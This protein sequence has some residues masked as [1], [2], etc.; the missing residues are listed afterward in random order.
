M[1]PLPGGAI[2]IKAAAKHVS[3]GSQGHTSLQFKDKR[4]PG[5]RHAICFSD[6]GDFVL[7]SGGMSSAAAQTAAHFICAVWHVRPK[8]CCCCIH[9]SQVLCSNIVLLLCV[10]VGGMLHAV[11]NLARTYVGPTLVCPQIVLQVVFSSKQ[12]KQQDI[13]NLMIARLVA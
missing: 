10:R 13:E 8:V 6:S 12:N 5:L 7:G 11:Y 2:V 9:Y 3:D 1:V 4:A